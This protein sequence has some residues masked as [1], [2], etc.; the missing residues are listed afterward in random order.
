MSQ[1]RLH[2]YVATKFSLVLSYEFHRGERARFALETFQDVMGLIEPDDN[3]LSNKLHADRFE[4]QQ[5]SNFMHY[6]RRKY[7]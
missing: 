2:C 6:V 3:F 5:T 7:T 4:R 1:M